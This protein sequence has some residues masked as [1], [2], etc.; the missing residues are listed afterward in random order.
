MKHLIREIEPE[1]TTLEMI[2]GCSTHTT[3]S[4]RAI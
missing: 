1:N 2:D 4:Y 3:Y